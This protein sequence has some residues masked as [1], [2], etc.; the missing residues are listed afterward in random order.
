MK[1]EMKGGCGKWLPHTIWCV[2]SFHLFTLFKKVLSVHFFLNLPG[3]S[4]L[5]PMSCQS[6]SS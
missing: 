1:E 3:I 2:L 5:A 6:L 4:S